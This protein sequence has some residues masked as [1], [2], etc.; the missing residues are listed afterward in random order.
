VGGT[1]FLGVVWDEIEEQQP[2]RGG[3]GDVFAAAPP[4]STGWLP[5]LVGRGGGA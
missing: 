4:P 2:S 3:G 1:V 5:Q